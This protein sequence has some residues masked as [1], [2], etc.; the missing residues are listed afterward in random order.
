[1]TNITI[2]DFLGKKYERSDNL[3]DHKKQFLYDLVLQDVPIDFLMQ[4]VFDRLPAA[5]KEAR[6]IS[7]ASFAAPEA[8][9]ILPYNRRA[10]A[11]EY[12]RMTAKSYSEMNVTIEKNFAKNNSFTQIRSGRIVMTIS[13]VN[14]PRE[15]VGGARFR[16]TLAQD[17]NVQYDLFIP[18]SEQQV[19][20]PTG[21]AY[22]AIFLHSKVSEKDD[23]YY[24]AQLAFPSKDC[25]RYVANI[26]L[27]TFLHL[28]GSGFKPSVE[29][30]IEDKSVPTLKQKKEKKI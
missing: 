15:L 1:M 20:P 22:Y 5:Y 13:A 8:K 18:V 25:K 2:Y 24:F 30:K 9:V 3:D 12:F 16:E 28:H 7:N 10:K 26:N 4:F 19:P 11:E 23:N 21:D 6:K 14:T 17:P 27:F 29:E